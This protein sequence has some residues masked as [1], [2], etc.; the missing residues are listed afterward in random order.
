MSGGPCR[1]LTN[2]RK[3]I[4]EKVLKC[5]GNFKKSTKKAFILNILTRRHTKILKRSSSNP[6][7][8]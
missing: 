7:S 2:E 1:I 8:T 5:T 4:R 6:E 3:M